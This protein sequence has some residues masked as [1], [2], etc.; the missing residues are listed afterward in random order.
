VSLSEFLE[1]TNNPIPRTESKH[2]S[3]FNSN[4]KENLMSWESDIF[5]CSSCGEQFPK[6]PTKLALHIRNKHEK[7]R[8]LIR[9]V[10]SN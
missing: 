9:N 5:V 7:E 6:N 1:T 2:E 4:F 3:L 10:S 8:D